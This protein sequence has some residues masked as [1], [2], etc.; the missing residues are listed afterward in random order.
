MADRRIGVA[1]LE[2]PESLPPGRA[3]DPPAAKV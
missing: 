1:R 2:V 3:A